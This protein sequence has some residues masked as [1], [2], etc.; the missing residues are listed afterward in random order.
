MKSLIKILL[1]VAVVAVLVAGAVKVWR[2][3]DH[4]I[5]PGDAQYRKACHRQG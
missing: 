4:T 2:D 1:A 5:E 3:R